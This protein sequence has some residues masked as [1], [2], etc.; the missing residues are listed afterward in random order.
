MSKESKAYDEL[1]ES[2]DE[3]NDKVEGEG[4]LALAYLNAHVTH[5]RMRVY[6]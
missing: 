2:C 6:L 3:R 1:K 5:T 4:Q